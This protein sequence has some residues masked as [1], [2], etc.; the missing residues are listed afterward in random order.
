MV[1]GCR[2]F[3]FG[4]LLFRW[5]AR[6]GWLGGLSWSVVFAPGRLVLAYNKNNLIIK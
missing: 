3:G 2:F 4:F 5:S 1:F 6:G